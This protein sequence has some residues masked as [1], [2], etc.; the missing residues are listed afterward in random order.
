MEIE[1][2]INNVEF[3][4]IMW[5]VGATLVFILADILTGF[6]GAIINKNLDSQKMREGLLRKMLLIVIIGLSFVIQYAIFNL[7]IISKAV[8]IYIIMM[9]VVSILENLQKSGIDLGKLGNIF[10]IKEE[11]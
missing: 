8:C 5:Q 7:E 10:K 6:I 1:Q 9:E 11:K 4:N 3:T 2:I